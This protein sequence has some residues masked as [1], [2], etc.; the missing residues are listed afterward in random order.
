MRKYFTIATLLFISPLAQGKFDSSIRITSGV[1]KLVSSLDDQK[2][3]ES[4]IATS[5]RPSQTLSLQGAVFARFVNKKQYWGIQMLTPFTLVVVRRFLSSYFAP[6]YRY[7][8]NNYS[9]P[10][11]EGGLKFHSMG[12]MGLGYRFIF[13]N[14]VKNGLKTESQFF[15]SISF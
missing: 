8:N 15:I 3:I 1:M 11:L 7:M 6:G 9:S 4:E 13:N 12:G 2:Y 14:W 10:I 5:Y